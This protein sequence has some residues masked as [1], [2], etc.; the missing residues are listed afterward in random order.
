[1]RE[2][3]RKV[4][5]NHNFAYTTISMW[6]L[7]VVLLFRLVDSYL[8]FLQLNTFLANLF[9]IRKSIVLETIK[10]HLPIQK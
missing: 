4:V 1:M 2:K 5:E 3:F 9:F 10:E 6:L 7:N 8:T